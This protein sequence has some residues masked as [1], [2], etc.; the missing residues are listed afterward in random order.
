MRARTKHAGQALQFNPRQHPRQCGRPSPAAVAPTS[1]TARHRAACIGSVVVV[2]NG[3]LGVAV[4][5]RQGADVPGNVYWMGG[6]HGRPCVRGRAARGGR[7]GARATKAASL[8]RGL[9]V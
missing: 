3:P 9:L 6:E 2:S 4:L 8:R 1:S 5:P 7:Q